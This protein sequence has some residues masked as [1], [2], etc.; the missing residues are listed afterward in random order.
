MLFI[1]MILQQEVNGMTQ[2]AMNLVSIA[3]VIQN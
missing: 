3:E 1:I 2:M